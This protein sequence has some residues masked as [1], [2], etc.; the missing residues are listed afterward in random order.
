MHSSG[1][2]RPARHAAR[3]AD[4]VE[5][6]EEALASLRTDGD[7]ATIARA[8]LALATAV[9]N[10]GDP[11]VWTLPEEAIVLLEPLGP[12]PDL[13]VALGHLSTNATLRGRP[14]EGARSPIG[15]WRSPTSS[16]FIP[17]MPSVGEAWR[18][19]PW[20]TRAAS[21]TNDRR[22]LSRPNRARVTKGPCSGT[23]WG[24]TFGAM[25]GRT[26]PLKPWPGD[27]VRAGARDRLASRHADPEQ[28]RSALRHVRA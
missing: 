13:V 4:A 20:G 28:T 22:S 19:P 27:L 15:R 25:R 11:R 3:H 18:G 21:R 9:T 17:L 6:L 23:T 24:W 10:L 7:H 5:A 14:E 26:H 12:T 8:M 1:S 16:A 2:V